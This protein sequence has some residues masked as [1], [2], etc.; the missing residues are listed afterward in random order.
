VSDAQPLRAW[1]LWLLT[2]ALGLGLFAGVYMTRH[3]DVVK[4]GS[5]QMQGDLIGCVESAK[6]SCDIVNTSE[7]ST[8]LGVPQFTWAIPM[9]TLLLGL[10]IYTLVK[11]DRRALWL[12]V[13]LGLF[14]TLYSFFLGYVSMVEVGKLC[15]WCIRLY[16]INLATPLLGALA[17]VR[18]AALPDGRLLAGA[19]GLWAVVA[20]GSIGGERA[21]RAGLIGDD[22]EVAD[23][24]SEAEAAA[25]AE[26]G[27]MDDPEGPPPALSW[28]VTTEDDQQATLTIEPDDAWKGAADAKVAVVEFADLECG[29]CKRAS[30]QLKRLMAAYG[31]RVA[32]V[33]KHY[34]MDPTCNPGV[35][36]KKHRYAC[37][38]AEAAVCAQDQ[39]RFWA[40]HDITFKN[41]HQLR[42][43]HLRSYAEAAGLDLGRFDA[44]MQSGEARQRVI[45][46]ANAGKALDTHGTPRIWIDGKLYRA[47]TSA[48][49]MARALE[50]ALGA[51]PAEATMAARAIR[52]DRAPIEPVPADVPEMRTIEHGGLSFEI[53][54]FEAGLTEGVA[55]SGKHQVPGLRMSWFAAR[56]ACEAAGKRLCTEEEW[57]TACQG[58]RAI[59]DDGDGEFADDLIEGSSYPYADHHERGRCWDDQRDLRPVYTGEMPG[60]VS[61]DGVYDLTGNAEE[62]VGSSPETAVLLGGAYDTSKDHARCYRRNDTFGAGYA[63]PRT[64]FRCCR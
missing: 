31:D 61:A 33:F 12:V 23:L 59:D 36:N 38:A 4:Y 19:A 27:P 63:S 39:G 14:N 22:I 9:Y 37:R 64:G 55:T 57:I 20:A 28:T 50:I 52:E 46:D 51:P 32:F 8:L 1:P 35:N 3:H 5:E 6:V 7:W 58:T 62:W 45:A 53:D 10:V 17:G 30:G 24:P 56:D 60:C 15:T 44:C 41:Q 48:E 49:Q 18:G 21:Y 11:R 42:D 34:P 29:Y 16:A 47:G 40:F 2:P 25:D 43:E 54:T 13:G 26:E